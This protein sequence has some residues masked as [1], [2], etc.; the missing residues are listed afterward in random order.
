MNIYMVDAGD[1]RYVMDRIEFTP[2]YD[3]VGTQ[4]PVVALTPGKARMYF[5]EYWAGE[6]DYGLNL[7]WL[8]IRH[9]RLMAKNVDIAEGVDSACVYVDSTEA[10]AS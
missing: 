7:D 10:V 9:V 5:L 4:T 8:D 6:L 2:I 3:R 1:Q